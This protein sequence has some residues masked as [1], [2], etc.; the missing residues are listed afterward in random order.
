MLHRTLDLLRFFEMTY[1]MEMDM[2]SG[3]WSV[4]G[5]STVQGHWRQLQDN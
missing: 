2:K 4:W 5:V 3:I 1:A